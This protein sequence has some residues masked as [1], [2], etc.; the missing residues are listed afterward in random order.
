MVSTG[1]SLAAAEA[2]DRVADLDPLWVEVHVPVDRLTGIEV[3]APA[4][5]PAMGI[6]GRV[7]GIGRQVHGEDQGVLVRAEIDKGAERL[8]PGQFVEVQLTL[9]GAGDAGKTWRVPSAAVIRNAGDAYVF[10]ARGDGFA[11]LPVRVLAEEERD[12]VVAGELRIDDR[13]AVSG[14]VAL[15]AAWLAGTE[16]DAGAD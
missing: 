16:P 14:T 12:T 2:L 11:V 8:R 5:L 4:L 3:G 15:K 9:A 1:Q 13:V 7:V 6:E 10:A